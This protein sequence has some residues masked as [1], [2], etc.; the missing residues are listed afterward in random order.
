MKKVKNPKGILKNVIIITSVNQKFKKFGKRETKSMVKNSSP[1]VV[2]PNKL[3]SKFKTNQRKVKPVV[4][5]KQ[6]Y[7]R[8]Y[9]AYHTQRSQ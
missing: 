5:P 3:K 4:P 9:S 1:L 6:K 7:R 8:S 2:T